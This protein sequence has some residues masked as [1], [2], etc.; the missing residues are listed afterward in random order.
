[1]DWSTWQMLS[2]YIPGLAPWTFDAEI[3]TDM[4]ISKVKKLSC[5]YIRPSYAQKFPIGIYCK[6]HRKVETLRMT[7]PTMARI[8]LTRPTHNEWMFVFGGT[9]KT[10]FR[11]RLCFNQFCDHPFHSTHEANRKSA[12]RLTCRNNYFQVLGR[13]QTSKLKA[14]RKC[15]RQCEH[16]PKCLPVG[17]SPLTEGKQQKE[18]LAV[19]RTAVVR[20]LQ[21]SGICSECGLDF[22]VKTEK[23]T[24]RQRVISKPVELR[25][26]KL[27]DAEC[28]LII[29]QL[30]IPELWFNAYHKHYCKVHMGL[31]NGIGVWAGMT[32][33]Q[34]PWWRSTL[35]AK[36][37]YVTTYGMGTMYKGELMPT[38][39]KIKTLATV[40]DPEDV[41][42]VHRWA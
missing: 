20:G 23:Y 42:D 5:I 15:H 17:S 31:K 28:E 9:G 39:Q 41:G 21:S 18:M 36:E 10:V 8:S 13:S 35:T 40:V 34:P 14:E 16:K 12:T 6:H 25:T 4:V 33:V 1:M 26:V 11:T 37:K 2:M 38:T 29:G 19:I 32:N 30:M 7:W 24:S 27:T 22:P 3:D